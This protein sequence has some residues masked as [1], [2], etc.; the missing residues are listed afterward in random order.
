MASSE[1]FV[2]YVT[3]QLAGAGEIRAKKMFGEYGLYCGE[4][5][6]ALICDNQF[7][8]KPTAAGRKLLGTPLERPPYKGASAYFLIDDLE[9]A[10][11]LAHLVSAT[12]AELPLPKPKRKK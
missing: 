4:K 7:F 1:D 2:G 8:I 10:P 9:N 5:F 3:A 11:F 12:C 6:F